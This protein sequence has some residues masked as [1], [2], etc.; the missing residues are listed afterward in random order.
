VTKRTSLAREIHAPDA[1]A[2]GQW[3]IADERGAR[4]AGQRLDFF[5]H[6]VVELDAGRMG[7]VFPP[8]KIQP[9]GENAIGLESGIGVLDA[10]ERAQQ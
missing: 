7:A 8:W 5:N 4:D 3:Q 6:A 2:P 10:P 1:A 9:H